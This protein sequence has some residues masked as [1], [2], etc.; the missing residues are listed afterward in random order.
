MKVSIVT[1][2][3][4]QAKYLEEAI[5]SVL[6]QDH[7]D[8]EYILVDAGS[9][10]GS[11]NIIKKYS[12]FIGTVIVEPDNGPADGLNKGFA[13]ARGDV[14]GYL[15]ADDILLPLAVSRITSYFH[16]EPDVDVIYG[17]GFFM[18]GSGR[19]GKPIFSSE[20]NTFGYA[21]GV[22]TI[23][24]PATFFRRSALP[25]AAP[26][27]KSNKTCWDGELLVDLAM[28]GARFKRVSGNF[29]CF[30]IHSKSITGSGTNSNEYRRDSER[31]AERILKR[32]K[33]GLDSF[34]RLFYFAVKH[35]SRPV[36]CGI[37][38]AQR[39]GKNRSS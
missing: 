29:A 12:E 36:A 7:Q 10:D 28:N 32:K 2:S 17:D 15:N 25:K 20:W 30:R 38:V 24:Q 22:V 14:I 27:N 3:F 16:S 4:N 26:F 1:I 37:T 9:T 35:I 23:L 39:L 11:I 6:R 19:R 13:L 21:H 8:I 31:I 18:D 33:R 5:N 34:M